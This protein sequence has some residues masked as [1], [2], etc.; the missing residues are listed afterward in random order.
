MFRYRMTRVL[1]GII[2]VNSATSFSTVS[3]AEDFAN[4]QEQRFAIGFGAAYV[5]FDSKYKITDKAS[6]RFVYIDPEGNLGLPEK[7][8]V[9]TVYGGFR[10]FKKHY[11]KYAFFHI[12]RESTLL[13]VN[14]NLDDLQGTD[15][16]SRTRTRLFIYLSN[17]S[18]HSPA[19]N[20]LYKNIV[21][22][23]L[24]C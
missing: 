22:T 13:N 20:L 5:N 4:I 2:L 9:N 16:E 1:M 10:F 24:L 12:N 8:N 14:K 7:D 3:H 6:G 18:M 17:S 21:N 19:G 23:T 11:F 15:S